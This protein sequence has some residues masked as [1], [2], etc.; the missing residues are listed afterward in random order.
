M[1]ISSQVDCCLQYVGQEGLGSLMRLR[2]FDF[3]IAVV[4]CKVA[5]VVAHVIA[6]PPLLQLPMSGAFAHLIR[7]TIR[8]DDRNLDRLAE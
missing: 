8:F 7:C 1:H 4:Y 3:L 5:L 2:V 6:P